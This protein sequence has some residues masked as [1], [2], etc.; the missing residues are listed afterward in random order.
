MTILFSFLIDNSKSRCRFKYQYTLIQLILYRTVT[1]SS[2][3]KNTFRV[4]VSMITTTLVPYSRQET[5]CINR[6]SL[7]LSVK[8]IN[9]ETYCFVS[10]V[11]LLTCEQLCTN[12]LTTCRKCGKFVPFVSSDVCCATS[13][14]VRST[15]VCVK[16][17]M[18]SFD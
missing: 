2:H 9:R 15:P 11:Y 7:D 12:Y 6:N 14:I 4:K 8:S 10:G 16:V 5:Y 1:G 17:G 3:A 13:A 18:Q